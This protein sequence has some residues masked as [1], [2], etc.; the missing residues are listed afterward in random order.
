MKIAAREEDDTQR[1]EINFVE[2]IPVKLRVVPK[3]SSVKHIRTSEAR[4]R[5]K[6]SARGKGQ[7]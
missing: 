5:V 2:Q 6:I 1:E 7:Y 4:E 3:F